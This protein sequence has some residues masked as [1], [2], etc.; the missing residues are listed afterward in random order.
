[1][2]SDA[3]T[4]GHNWAFDDIAAAPGWIVESAKQ[5]NKTLKTFHDVSMI[6]AVAVLLVATGWLWRQLGLGKVDPTTVIPWM[7]RL[8]L[9]PWM[10][11]LCTA[12]SAYWNFVTPICKSVGLVL[13][14]LIL[15]VGYGKYAR[16]PGSNRKGGCFLLSVLVVAVMIL[17]FGKLYTGSNFGHGKARLR[18]Y[19]NDPRLEHF[20]PLCTQVQHTDNLGLS[21]LEAS[22]VYDKKW[23]VYTVLKDQVSKPTEAE[24]RTLESGNTRSWLHL[25]PDTNRT[26]YNYLV[27]QRQEYKYNMPEY[28]K[29]CENR[30]ASC[31]PRTSPPWYSFRH[32]G[33][34]ELRQLV[35]HVEMVLPAVTCSVAFA[36]ESD[37]SQ[38]APEWREAIESNLTLSRDQWEIETL[39]RL[40]VWAMWCAAVVIIVIPVY[41]YR[42][43]NALPLTA[44]GIIMELGIKTMVRNK[45]IN[46][47]KVLDLIQNEWGLSPTVYT[48][49]LKL[50][51]KFPDRKSVV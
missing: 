26:L 49:M 11:G 45:R 41:V 8:L 38:V 12:E 44:D 34:Q 25:F 13:V 39:P 28:C 2:N 22:G 24:L 5:L 16:C 43:V 50:A 23:A 6:L 30:S 18:Q 27:G 29:K 7:A 31:P 10:Y 1:M 37:Y 42:Y 3:A 33:D 21:V 4:T 40:K 17:A 47:H 36:A 48:K 15:A 20:V 51:N 46:K 35:V 32:I 9:L 19:K 14:A